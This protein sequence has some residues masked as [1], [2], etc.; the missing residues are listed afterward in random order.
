MFREI[1]PNLLPYIAASF[2]GA[3]AGAMLAAVGLEALGLGTNDVH[4][5]GT[6][7]YWAAEVQ[8]RAARPVVVVGPADR[9]D[10]VHLHRPCS[11]C[12]PEWTASPTRKLTT[13]AR[14]RADGERE[15]LRVEDLRVHYQTPAGR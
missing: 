9:G 15:V 6:T 14:E 10:R 7:I 1:M 12:R 5:L 13:R 8:R 2:V 4:T 3:V 11:V